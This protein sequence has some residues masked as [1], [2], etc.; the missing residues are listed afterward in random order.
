MGMCVSKPKPEAQDKDEQY[1]RISQTEP[2]A[3]IQFSPHIPKKYTLV[4]PPD[5][6]RDP[7]CLYAVKQ[8]FWQCLGYPQDRPSSL[9]GFKALDG[10]PGGRSKSSENAPLLSSDDLC[11]RV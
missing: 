5:S 7:D 2:G 6:D 9:G 4:G 10:V 1:E 11:P 8:W 3:I